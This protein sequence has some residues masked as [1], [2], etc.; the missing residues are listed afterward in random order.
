MENKADFIVEYNESCKENI[1]RRD[2]DWSQT[3]VIFVSTNFTENQKLATNFK[4]IAIELYEVKQYEGGIISINP[5][6]K[7][8]SATSIQPLMEKDEAIKNITREIKVYSEED[9]LT[10][11]RDEI[12]ELYETYKDAILNLADNIEIVPRKQQIGFRQNGIIC[13]IHIQKKGLKMW[14]NLKKGNLDDPKKIT[15]DV[16]ETGHWGNGDY[17]LLITDTDNLEYIMSLVKQAL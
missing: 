16:S 6:K 12:K 2:V 11:I 10:N 15:R 9:H 3:R 8:S 7:S 14:I 17:E 4:D 5:I 13:D 1:Q